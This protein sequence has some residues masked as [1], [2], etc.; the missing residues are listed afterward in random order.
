VRIEHEETIA[1]PPAEVFAYLT[2]PANLP[3]WQSGITEVRKEDDRH[4]REV[5]RVLGRHVASDVEVTTLEPPR[6]FDLTVRSGPL[7]VEISHRLE[8]AE[9]GTRVRVTGEANAG[10]MGPFVGRRIEKQ[11]ERDFAK[12]KSVLEGRSR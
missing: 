2:D 12:L 9:N 3:E 4:F 7:T 1:R 6:R 10:V 5:R 8:P 11:V